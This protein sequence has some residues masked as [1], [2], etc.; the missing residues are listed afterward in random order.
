M[1]GLFAGRRL[2]VLPDA[3]RNP[4]HRM[5]TPHA[6]P[7]RLVYNFFK[8]TFGGSGDLVS[9]VLSLVTDLL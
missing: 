3:G 5:Q 6:L 8:P 1:V 4:M 2:R 7:A 9:Q